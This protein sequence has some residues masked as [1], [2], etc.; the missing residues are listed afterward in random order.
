MTALILDK[1]EKDQENGG[2]DVP[3]TE[4]YKQV[5]FFADYHLMQIYYD[6]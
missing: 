5:G 2:E 1:F 3:L 6:L 4:N